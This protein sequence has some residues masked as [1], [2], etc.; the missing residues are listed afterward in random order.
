MNSCADAATHLK[1]NG[2]DVFHT[3]VTQ[4]AIK[5]L[6]QPPRAIQ[7]ITTPIQSPSG[8]YGSHPQRDSN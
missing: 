4:A 1:T 7:E 6:Q 3:Q 2:T 5:K 8:N